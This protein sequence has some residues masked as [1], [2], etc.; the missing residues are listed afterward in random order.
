MKQGALELPSKLVAQA[1]ANIAQGLS[2]W[3]N[4]GGRVGWRYFQT[5]CEDNITR[6][7]HTQITTPDSIAPSTKL[8][9]GEGRDRAW[10]ALSRPITIKTTRIAASRRPYAMKTA[11]DHTYSVHRSHDLVPNCL[12]PVPFPILCN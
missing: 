5:W 11:I 9:L 7:S 3:Y 8:S 6:E 2:Y 4:G 12:L 10:T 1:A